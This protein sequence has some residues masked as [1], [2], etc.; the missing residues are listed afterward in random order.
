MNSKHSA[1]E[2]NE[3]TL[4]QQINGLKTQAD[5]EKKDSAVLNMFKQSFMQKYNSEL[6]SL[7]KTHG[8]EKD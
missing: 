2:E 6:A 8:E 3:K 1:K 5:S 7:V 4:L